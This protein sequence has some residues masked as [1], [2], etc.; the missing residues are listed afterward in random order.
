MTIEK[1]ES[2]SFDIIIVLPKIKQTE[3]PALSTS[4]T[5]N[6]YDSAEISGS[7]STF[8]KRFHVASL[9]KASN[10]RKA[11]GTSPA[12]ILEYMFTLIFK[13]KSMYMD[14]LMNPS[15][16]SACTKDAVN[17]FMKNGAA[18]WNRFSS[19]LASKIVETV[20]IPADSKDRVNA[21]IVD[22]SVFS[23]NRSKKVELLT[24]IFDHAHQEYLFG[25]RML[26][27]SWTDGNTLLPVAGSLL[28]SENQKTRINEAHETDHRSN[29]YKR[30][31]LS[32]TKGTDAM[33]EL[34]KEAKKAKLPADY[35]LFDSW[36]SSPKT[37]LTIKNLG[38]DVIAMLKKSGKMKFDYNGEMKSVKEIYRM[39]HK[40]RGRSKYLLSVAVNVTR[41]GKSIPAR[42][43]YVKN[44]SSRKDYLCLISTNTDIDE[45]EIIRIYGKRW[46]IEVFF[47]VCKSYLGLA[48][49]CHSLSYDAMSAHVAV[50]FARYMLLAV[51]NRESEDPRTL[52]ELFLYFIDELAD[53]TFDQA[54][55]QVMEMFR[56]EIRDRF[57]LDEST[58]SEMMDKFISV[59][60]PSTQR[61]LKTA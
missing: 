16:G 40:R 50:V 25:F 43:V 32:L 39:N 54:F 31:K 9:L 22:D 21:L 59:L 4:I 12:R 19:L 38:Y 45:N 15:D 56:A 2:Q 5:Q 24:R 1:A 20:I 53:I 3:V 51:E 13:G 29:A 33:I 14:H 27:V 26:T 44:R 23:R 41:D 11:K 57:N 35:V 8:F 47:K 46:Q 52:G 61:Q 28:S 18:N 7:I 17:R 6:D 60:R 36:F 55:S 48:S 58:I 30:R 37:L 34:I 10:I 49:E 42:L